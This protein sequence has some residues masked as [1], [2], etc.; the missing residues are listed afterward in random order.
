MLTAAL[1]GGDDFF[2]TR[3]H[4]DWSW[5]FGQVAAIGG[6]PFVVHVVQDGS[7]E[8]D[9]GGCR[10]SY[11]AHRHFG[12]ATSQPRTA[13]ATP[14]AISAEG[15]TRHRA[16]SRWSTTEGSRKTQVSEPR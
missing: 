15:P 3:L 14:E 10:G 13:D 12:S 8:P 4:W 2:V 16:P 11:A 6:N 7:N 9:D 1:D 5:A